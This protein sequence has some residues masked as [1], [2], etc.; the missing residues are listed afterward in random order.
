M[1]LGKCVELLRAAREAGCGCRLRHTRARSASGLSGMSVGSVA[2]QWDQWQI[3]RQKIPTPVHVGQQAL[4]GLPPY[5]LTVHTLV[6]LFLMSG[7]PSNH[8]DVH[9]PSA[10]SSRHALRSSATTTTCPSPHPANFMPCFISPGLTSVSPN[11]TTFKSVTS[12][13]SHDAMGPYFAFLREMAP[14]RRTGDGAGSAHHNP[15]AVRMPS[16]ASSSLTLYP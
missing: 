6:F 12:E 16:S 5:F 11:S 15:T 4:R 3:H 10:R 1:A 7:R 2:R 13:T 14:P 8:A 9:A